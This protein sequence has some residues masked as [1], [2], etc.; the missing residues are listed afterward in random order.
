[1]QDGTYARVKVKLSSDSFKSG[2]G[3]G[4]INLITSPLTPHRLYCAIP[5][6]VD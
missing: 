5:F 6:L 2:G 1:M 3:V 4:D